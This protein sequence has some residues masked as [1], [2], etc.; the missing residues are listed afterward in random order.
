[1]CCKL[2][3]YSPCKCQCTVRIQTSIYCQNPLPSWTR[4]MDLKQISDDAP[5][6]FHH[7]NLSWQHPPDQYFY[8]AIAPCINQGSPCGE[9]VVTRHCKEL[10]CSRRGKFIPLDRVDKAISGTLP[11]NCSS[12]GNLR[13]WTY[14]ILS[15]IA[16]LTVFNSLFYIY[17]KSGWIFPLGYEFVL[18]SCKEV[19]E[20]SCVCLTCKYWCV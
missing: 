17:N 2:L 1:M 7:Q 18:L 13:Q 10:F 16:P 5:C 14:M 15:V 6:Q 20:Y 4:S 12:T 9:D 19:D 11:L 3:R 8:L